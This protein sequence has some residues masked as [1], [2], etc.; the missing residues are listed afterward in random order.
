MGCEGAET[1]TDL[2]IMKMGWHTIWKS[3]KKTHSQTTGENTVLIIVLEQEEYYQSLI[4]LL[5]DYFL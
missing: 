3:Q 4:L 1:P 2:E 5:K